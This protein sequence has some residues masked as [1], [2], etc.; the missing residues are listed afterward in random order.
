MCL[1]LLAELKVPSNSLLVGAP[2]RLSQDMDQC[3]S[4]VTNVCIIESIISYPGGQ[5]KK[6]SPSQ[7]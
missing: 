3:L 4:T 1:L 2:M 6:V 7:R 5:I